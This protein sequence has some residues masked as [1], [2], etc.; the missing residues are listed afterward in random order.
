VRR[1]AA[2]LFALAV[3]ACENNQLA[4]TGSPFDPIHFFAD[5]TGG[6]A[7]LHTITGSSHAISVD[8][9]GRPDGQGGLALDQRVDEQGKLA[10]TRRWVLH[11][12]GPNRWTGTLTDSAGPVA[13]ER[14]ASDVVIRYRMH[15]GANVEQHLALVGRG[16]ALNHM[17]ISRF[18]LRLATLDERIRKLD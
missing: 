7:T 17:I 16:V 2:L 12:A 14:T 11:P 15:S 10:R 6:T 1:A 13:V 3:S 8:S 5:H 4:A 9:H 18:G